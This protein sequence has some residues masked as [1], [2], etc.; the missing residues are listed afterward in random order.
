VTSGWL[1]VV[2]VVGTTVVVVVHAPMRW[3][4][5]RGATTTGA[6]EPL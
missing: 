4:L 2:V 1:V 3:R 6:R 5:R